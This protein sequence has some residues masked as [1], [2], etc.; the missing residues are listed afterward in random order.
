LFVCSCVGRGL[1][2]S[3]DS[4]EKNNNVTSNGDRL[5]APCT[6]AQTVGLLTAAHWDRHHFDGQRRCRQQ[7][8]EGRNHSRDSC[9]FRKKQKQMGRHWKKKDDFRPQAFWMDSCWRERGSRIRP[10]ALCLKNIYDRE[11][12]GESNHR[13]SLLQLG[14][15]PRSRRQSG[16]KGAA[17]ECL[18]R[19]DQRTDPGK[20]TGKLECLSFLNNTT[21]QHD[22]STA[23][24]AGTLAPNSRLT[25]AA[26]QRTF[27][28]P[29]R[30]P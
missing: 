11:Y 3:P 5:A 17:Q 30:T 6:A 26:H 12:R 2:T 19:L 1:I 22:L 24:A 21:K 16:W 15:F 8:H 18:K 20:S 7:Q 25:K 28:R 29:I 10:R 14:S 9:H 23:R 4:K 13:L 27:S